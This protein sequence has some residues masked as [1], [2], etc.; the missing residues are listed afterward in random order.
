MRADGQADPDEGLGS[1]VKPAAPEPPAA[2]TQ[3]LPVV[4]VVAEGHAQSA[5]AV[6]RS[7]T[8]PECGAVAEITVNRRESH[9]FCP[10]CDFPL[11][12]TP[13]QL[14]LSD[15][16]SATQALRRL[17]GTGGRVTVGS[18]AC[19]HCEEA[20]P[21]TGSLCLR[22]GGDLHPVA[23]PPAPAPVVVAPPPPVADPERSI[24][25]WWWVLGTITL[26]LLV[27]VVVVLLQG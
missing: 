16:D 23:P 3:G 6:G 2:Q 22:C 1:P 15:A 19:P 24:P 18:V 9:D 25:L 17:P 11:F 26:F 5:Q 27:A 14:V 21:I 8:C 4:P 10:R 13:A 7:V 20:N 12:W